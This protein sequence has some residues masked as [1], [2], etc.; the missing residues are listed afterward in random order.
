[1]RALIA[2][3]LLGFSSSAVAGES[4]GGHLSD[5]DTSLIHKIAVVSAVGK[6]LYVRRVGFTAFQNKLEE[7]PIS[8]WAL[9][10]KV[11][12]Q[13]EKVLSSTYAVETAV[14]APETYPADS[15][16]TALGRTVYQ[17]LVEQGRKQGA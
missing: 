6:T 14:V 8:D 16:D 15:P 4:Y 10:E 9:D 17:S 11:A 1:M 13:V 12:S 7:V 5:A 2:V 3:A